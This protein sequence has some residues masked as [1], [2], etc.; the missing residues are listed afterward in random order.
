[1]FTST[2]R[3]FVPPP[4]PTTDVPLAVWSSPIDGEHDNPA[5]SPWLTRLI[6]EYAAAGQPVLLYTPTDPS[7]PHQQLDGEAETP[8]AAEQLE[9]T[10]A[11]VGVV[12]A[13]L[14]QTTTS[15]DGFDRHVCNAVAAISPAGWLAVVTHGGQGPRRRSYD[16]VSRTVDIARRLGFGFVQHLIITDPVELAAAHP[17]RHRPAGMPDHRRTHLDVTVLQAP[18][19]VD[20][21]AEVSR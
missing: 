3:F 18:A 9:Q 7:G 14:H 12:L 8:T 6:N 17:A 20:R 11:P 10:P 1:M 21:P 4:A 2:I 15:A 13:L 5:G 19:G 16:P